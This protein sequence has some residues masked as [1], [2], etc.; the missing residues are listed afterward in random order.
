M[1]ASAAQDISIGG[2]DLAAQAIRADLVDDYYLVVVPVVVGGGSRALPEDVRLDLA[3][4]D[5]RR[6][7]NGTVLL[8]YRPR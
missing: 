2:P 4:V 8:H 1:K 6:F 7:D 3:L 5:E